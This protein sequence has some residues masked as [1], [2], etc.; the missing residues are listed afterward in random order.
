VHGATT[1]A[2]N[3]RSTQNSS[4]MYT[5]LITSV[6]DG[7]LA[8]IISKRDKDYT[9]VTGFQDRPTLLKVIVTILHV[10]TRAQ[11][12]YI[13]Q[14]L[15]RLSIM[16][17]MPACHHNIE[18]LNEYGVVLEEGLAARGGAS[19]D[20]LLNVQTA[21]AVYKDAD[22]VRHAKDKYACWEQGANMT[23][24]EYMALACI[25]YQTLMM[26]IIWEVPS[27]EQEQII[28]LVASVSLLKS[29]PEKVAGGKT[30]PSQASNARVPRKNDGAF[31]WKN[32]APKAD[33]PNETRVKERDYFWCN[34]HKQPQW[35][36]HNPDAFPNL[37]K[38]HPKYLE[39]KAALKSGASDP[40]AATADSI[41][42]ESA[43]AAVL[44]SDLEG[45]E[46]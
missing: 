13:W 6:T 22:F 32:V 8:K 36:L 24:R 5:F 34:L 20:T 12:G 18:K 26:K 9:M 38:Y 15:E 17:L 27:P 7:L 28:A 25:K 16:I 1:E 23:L 29:R 30:A 4:Q 10:D 21:Y 39:L 44:D 19:Q 31:P 43:L 2:V 40:G 37:C 46:L 45:E 41:Q 11:A 35:T 3:G 33:K 14:G 42:M